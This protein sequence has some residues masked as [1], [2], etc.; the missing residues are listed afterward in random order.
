[1]KDYF[2]V[3]SEMKENFVTVT[4]VATKGYAPQDPGAKALVTSEGLYAGTVGGGKVEAAAIQYAKDLLSQ[5]NSAPQFVKWNLQK[6]IGMSCG[7]EVEFLFEGTY[8]PDWN[9]V[10]FGAG[11][12]SQALTPLLLKLNCTLTC[13]DT[14]QEWL[15]RLPSESHGFKKICLKEY[16]VS[17]LVDLL[18]IFPHKTYFVITTKGHVTDVPVLESISNAEIDP[19]YLGVI[20]SKVKAIR[21]K[22]DL[23]E[24]GVKAGLI[25][26]LHCPMGLDIGNTNDPFEIAISITAHLIETHAKDAQAQGT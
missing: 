12:I 25:E 13:I 11:H 21:I 26:N 22:K 24:L 23:L 3:A 17:E 18:K 8:R 1:M 9:I 5:Q 19:S 14:R 7:G 15:Q 4:L 10:V 20:G 6:D 16:V 2:R